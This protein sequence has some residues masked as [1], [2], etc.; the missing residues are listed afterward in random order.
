MCHDVYSSFRHH[1]V[2]T[3]GGKQRRKIKISEGKEENLKS[4]KCLF[5]LEVP[6]VLSAI[7]RRNNINAQKAFPLDFIDFP[8]NSESFECL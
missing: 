6:A 1:H 4:E 2:N 5:L 8:L 7:T 3:R